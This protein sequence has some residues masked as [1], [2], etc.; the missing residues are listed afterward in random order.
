[1]RSTYKYLDKTSSL[2]ACL[3]SL[4]LTVTA[5]TKYP[6]SSLQNR[7]LEKPLSNSQLSKD[8]LVKKYGLV[9]LWPMNSSRNL[10]EDSILGTSLLNK[11]FNVKPYY[12]GDKVYAKF[13]DIGM[14]KS[15]ESLYLYD[16]FSEN[17]PSI[18]E[19]DAF[20]ARKGL[21]KLS[22]WFPNYLPS[23]S[24]DEKFN[25]NEKLLEKYN[26][27]IKNSSSLVVVDKKDNKFYLKNTDY[28]FGGWFK[29]QKFS[30]GN[31]SS[32]RMTL[33][34]KKYTNLNGT[35]EIKEWEIFTHGNV[36][37]FHNYHDNSQPVP[38]SYLTTEQSFIFRSKNKNFYGFFDYYDDVSERTQYS[39]SIDKYYLP[40]II[41]KEK[42]TI[43]KPMPILPPSPV[44]P[45]PTPV[46]PVIIPQP[47]IPGYVVIPPTGKDYISSIDLKYF[48]HATILGSCY[49][50]QTPDTH[51]DVWHYISFSV[52]LNDPLGPYVDFWIIMDPNPAYF[53][54]TATFLRHAKHLR[55]E[56]D[57]QILSQPVLNPFKNGI[58]VERECSKTSP[59]DFAKGTCLNSVLEVGSIDLKTAYSGFMRGI[60]LSKKALREKEVLDLAAQY[61]PDDSTKFCTYEKAPRD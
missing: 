41:P 38:L 25:L 60:Y 36:I 6:L 22:E 47:T 51:S 18:I 1:M 35:K 57:K 14:I 46:A 39:P 27:K 31:F 21:S 24:S 43:R 3:L 10:V 55:W 13:E 28:T 9:R 8:D 30:N 23:V 54:S 61:Y 29:P 4:T 59:K 49:S 53:K 52:H 2:F 40:P 32:E 16:Y 5:E 19:S 12:C 56:L 11:N 26:E 50:C 58:E 7:M 48:W 42:T 20:K 17:K 45:L 37:F 34:T 44:T 33:I 15:D